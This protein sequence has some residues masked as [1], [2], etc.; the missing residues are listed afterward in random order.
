MRRQYLARG[1]ISDYALDA[2][3]HERGVMLPGCQSELPVGFRPSCDRFRMDWLMAVPPC[4]C[5]CCC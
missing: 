1:F 2:K 4:G 5:P 3:M